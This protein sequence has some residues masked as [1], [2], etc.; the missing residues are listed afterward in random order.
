MP[1]LFLNNFQTQFIASVLAAPASG[2][3]ASELGYGVLRVSDGAAG[4][5]LSPGEGNWYVLTAFK[6]S[7]SAESDYEVVRVTAVDN[8]TLGECRLTVLRGQEGTTPKAY[9]AGDM[10]E[11]RLTKGG[12]E[13]NVQTTDSRLSDPRP[14]TGAAGGVLSGQYPNPAFAQPMATQAGLELKVDKVP[15][16]GLSANDFT[17]EQLAKLAGI[18]EQATK[19]AA[20]SQLRDR[21]THTGV[22]AIGTVTDLQSALD[23]KEPG[24]A[25]GTA[26]QYWRG[27]KTWRDFAADVRAA[28]LTGLSTAT[29]AAVTAA[30]SVLAAFGKLQAQL[31]AHFGSGGAAHAAASGAA[32]GFMSL[33]DKTKMDG[34]AAGAT[35]NATDAQLRD[36]ATHTGTQAI[37]TVSG[38]QAALDAVTTQAHDHLLNGNFDVWQR[39]AAYGTSRVLSASYTSGM[40]LADRWLFAADAGASGSLTCSQQLFPP[41]QTDV[42]NNPTYFYRLTSSNFS[43][44]AN[45]FTY[46]AGQRIE[47][48]ST[49]A[50]KQVTVSYR[51]KASV[52]CSLQLV[53]SQGF[54]TG[55]SAGVQTPLG[56][57]ALTTAWQWF[58]HTV[59][60]PPIAGKTVGADNHLYLE[61]FSAILGTTATAYGVAPLMMGANVSI[62]L[63]QVKI[64]EGA[65]ATPLLPRLY[66]QEL[67]LC[68]RYLPVFTGPGYIGTGLSTNVTL[69]YAVAYFPVKTRVPPTGILVSSPSD[70]VAV[71]A[72]G[73]SVP[74]TSLAVNSTSTNSGAVTIGASSGA[75]TPSGPLLFS[76]NTSGAFLIFTG[77]EL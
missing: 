74:V 1:Q 18:A 8:S 12:M 75:L 67:A 19:N 22:Q 4:V 24:I 25:G 52:A 14:P 6:R 23:G 35:A 62:D 72:A 48:V 61:M 7:G 20:D 43:N 70:Y 17:N 26:A 5:L 59:T 27:D 68:Q 42:P 34:I 31:T 56:R 66:A 9:A 49:Y 28:A 45:G 39:V 3:P 54:G 21:S 47:N 57:P 15:G 16:K 64:Q 13:Q 29:N 76:G 11:L 53:L 2:N 10:L 38:L 41:G 33:A 44:G 63:A 32:A 50:G 30:D 65:A 71:N 40:S 55:G 60:L 69:G 37:A 77:A 58:S 51:A 36:R 73:S 46:L